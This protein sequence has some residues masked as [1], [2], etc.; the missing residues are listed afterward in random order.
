MKVNFKAQI[1]T[2]NSK[3]LVSGDFSTRILL[4]Q[5]NLPPEILNILN[6]LLNTDINKSK[7]LNITINT[8]I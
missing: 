1:K 2:I 3:S 4:E 7:E 5:D 6:T 8:D